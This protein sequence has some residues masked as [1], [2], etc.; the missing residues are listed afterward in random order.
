MRMRWPKRAASPLREATRA[1]RSARWER[2]SV[3][4]VVTSGVRF[5]EDLRAAWRASSAV[6]TW[7]WI[8]SRSLARSSGVVVTAAKA[9]SFVGV[10]SAR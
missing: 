1:R 5:V 6:V 4:R 2:S 3:A 10:A 7:W 9:G 8:R